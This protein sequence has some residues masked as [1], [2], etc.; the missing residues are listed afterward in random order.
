MRM[1]PRRMVSICS[2]ASTP[3]T[4]GCCTCRIRVPTQA[5]QH[6]SNLICTV[7]FHKGL[8]LAC[9]SFQMFN[10]L[11]LGLTDFQALAP[12]ERRL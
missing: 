2:S 6:E 7:T 8:V 4:V 9:Q 1:R 5:P 3:A 11:Q 12:L 10:L